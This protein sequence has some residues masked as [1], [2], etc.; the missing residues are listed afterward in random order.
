M[1]EEKV[2]SQEPKPYRFSVALFQRLS[3]TGF[4]DQGPKVELLNG[5]LIEVTEMGPRHAFTVNQLNQRLQAFDSVFVWMQCPVQI[6]QYSSPLPDIVLLKKPEA[7][8]ANQLPQ[9]EQ[10]LLVIEIADSSL[11][12]DRQIKLPLYASAG[13]Q[14]YWIVN[15]VDNQ[16]EVY[17]DPKGADYLTRN[18]YQPGTTVQALALSESIAW[19]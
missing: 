10:V 18:T 17:R 15:L 4:F 16:L 9:P 19:D 13:I 12:I 6:P 8:Y 5:K 11:N 3:E 2:V 7:Q 14:E 1:V